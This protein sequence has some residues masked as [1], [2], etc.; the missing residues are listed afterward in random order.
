MKNSLRAILD[1]VLKFLACYTKIL[2]VTVGALTRLVVINNI[3]LVPYYFD[4]ILVLSFILSFAFSTGYFRML[5]V[6]CDER[7]PDSIEMSTT[8]PTPLASS[9]LALIIRP[10]LMSHIHD[11]WCK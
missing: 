8:P 4:S 9:L 1:M 10:L 2:S 5:R 7:V 6:V 11:S 3:V